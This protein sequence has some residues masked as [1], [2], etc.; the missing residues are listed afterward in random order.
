M[1]SGFKKKDIAKG[2]FNV[3]IDVPLIIKERD[4]N[5]RK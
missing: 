5:E 3:L 2:F 4:I 1:D